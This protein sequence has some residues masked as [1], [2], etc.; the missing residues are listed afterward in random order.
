MA[1]AMDAAVWYG[2]GRSNAERGADDTELVDGE[3]HGVLLRGDV[4][5]LDGIRVCTELRFVV[6]GRYL[7]RAFLLRRT[8]YVEG[9]E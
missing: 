4:R 7:D 5:M 2:H 3:E 9:L 6:Y 8:D 1:G